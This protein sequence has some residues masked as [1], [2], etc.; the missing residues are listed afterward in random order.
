MLERLHD[1]LIP[2]LCLQELLALSKTCKQWNQW[3]RDNFD[4][5]Y[6]DVSLGRLAI[7][8]LKYSGYVQ[9]IARDILTC[10]SIYERLLSGAT[11]FSDEGINCI[12]CYR[13][14][15]KQSL[16]T[17]RRLIETMNQRRTVSIRV[18]MNDR[19]VMLG[20]LVRDP[21]LFSEFCVAWPLQ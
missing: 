8:Y 6:L 10:I 15:Y 12:T 9:Y 17:Q 13:D 14:P 19:K 5:T 20:F 11:R 1:T 4:R 21:Q 2:R 16:E 3:F 7:R 18:R